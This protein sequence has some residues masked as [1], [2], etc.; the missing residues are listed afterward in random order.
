MPHTV[1][2]VTGILTMPATWVRKG[3]YKLIR[4][5]DTGPEFPDKFELYNLREDIGETDNLAEKMPEKVRELD[6]LIERFL[7]ETGAA[8]PR[9]NPDYDPDALAELDGWRP[10]G[11]ARI[12]RGTGSLLLE[13]TGGDP[14]IYVNTAPPAHGRLEF[15]FRMRSRAKGGGMTFWSTL[16][17]RAFGPQRRPPFKPVHDGEWHEYA[18]PFTCEGTLHALRIDPATAPGVIEFDWIRLVNAKGEELAGWQFER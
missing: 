9:P 6:A 13:S 1:N 8:V 10:S 17:N 14:F 11:D 4:F 2:S 18:V 5:Y 7:G 15:R 3:D 16:E 12:Q